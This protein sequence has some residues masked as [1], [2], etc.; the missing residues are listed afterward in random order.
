MHKKIMP[1][2]VALIILAISIMPWQNAS[3]SQSPIVLPNSKGI[4]CTSDYQNAFAALRQGWA[5]NMEALTGQEIPADK[6]VDDAMENLRTYRCWLEYVC[7]AVEY[8]GRGNP[9]YTEK[10]GLTS[11]QI[12]P[13]PGCQ[14]PEDVGLPSGFEVFIRNLASLGYDNVQ[15]KYNKFSFMN[16]CMTSPNNANSTMETAAKAGQNYAACK[17]DLEK[18][19]SGATMALEVQLK[20][21]NAKQK[22]GVLEKKLADIVNKMHGMEDHAQY[23]AGKLF[24]VAQQFVCYA[25]RCSPYPR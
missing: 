18:E 12:A 15:L 4:D 10:T 16:G 2:L 8:S 6:M 9:K 14:K 24:S 5:K 23:M 25:K 11:D 21:T 20:K 19:K 3:Y 13:F 17:A 22:S 7:E 1:F